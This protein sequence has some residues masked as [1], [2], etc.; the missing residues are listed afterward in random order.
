M[1][2]P[3]AAA[4]AAQEAGLD[5][6]GI[7]DARADCALADEARRRGIAVHLNSAVVAAKGGKCVTA[8]EIATGDSR[9]A[10]TIAC[11]VIASSGGWT[12][13]VQLFTQSG[14]TLRFDEASGGFVPDRSAQAEQSCGA[15][16]GIFDLGTCL[17]SGAEAGRFAAE[18][19]GYTAAALDISSCLRMAFTPPYTAVEARGEAKNMLRRSADRCDLGRYGSGRARKLPVAGTCEA[20]HRVGH[21][22]RSG[23][24]QRRQW[25]FRAGQAAGLAAR[26][27]GHDEISP[28]FC[29]RGA[30]HH[31]SDAR[32]GQAAAAVATPA[33]T[34]LA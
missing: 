6:R 28:A 18:Q 20:L 32:Q 8:A 13:A 15:A 14:G 33:R 34:W 16:A 26:R 10:Q 12:P 1:I 29:A 23:P 3:I 19:C 2:A 22:H 11:D 31:R 25:R 4:F 27:A 9:Q 30:E 5:V 24:P 21:G 7:V 17:K